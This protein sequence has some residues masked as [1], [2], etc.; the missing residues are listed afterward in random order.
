MKQIIKIIVSTLLLISCTKTPSVPKLYVDGVKLMAEG[1]DTPVVLNGVSFS[2]H[3][4][5]PSKIAEKSFYRTNAVNQL[6]QDWACKVVRAAIGA[7]SLWGQPSAPGELYGYIKEPEYT[8]ERLFEVIDAC[9]ANGIYVIVDWHSHSLLLDEATDFFTKVATQYADCPNVIYELYN[10][11]V[12]DTWEDLKVYAE[13]LCNTISSISNVHPLILMGCPHWDQDINLPA[14]DPI[15]TYDNIMYTMHFYAATHKQY[16]IDRTA[17][18]IASGLP[19]FISECA[20]CEASG[21]GDFDLESWDN[22][23]SWAKANDV[24]VVAWSIS[25]KDETCSM[26]IPGTDPLA[27]WTEDD[28]KPWGKIV[29]NWLKQSK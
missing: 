20:A 23:T 6:T 10:E 14:A 27:L 28:I 4:F 19:V 18:A 13:S 5:W 15:K 21:D 8:L 17:D 22:W 24:S 16:L 29:R 12:N 9:I 3:N 1:C 7:E 2:W 25:E 11:P 26:L